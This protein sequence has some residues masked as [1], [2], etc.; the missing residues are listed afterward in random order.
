M[1]TLISLGAVSYTLRSCAEGGTVQLALGLGIF[2]AT[3]AAVLTRPAR[4]S[5]AQAALLGAAALLVAGL[6]RPGEAVVAVLR[7]WNV[8]L[9]FLGLVATAALADRAGVFT[10]LAGRCA[11]SMQ[12]SSWWGQW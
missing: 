7:E 5:E 1:A 9:F 4:L 8:Y 6:V 10:F 2:L 12:R 11:A 3:L